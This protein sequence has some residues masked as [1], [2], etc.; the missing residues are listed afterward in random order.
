MILYLVI[1]LTENQLKCR[2]AAHEHMTH[3]AYTLM[4]LH[5]LT[6]T[7]WPEGNTA[8]HLT[9]TPTQTPF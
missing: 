1:F 7:L 3:F 5:L 2:N 8:A 4:P 6:E 9:Q